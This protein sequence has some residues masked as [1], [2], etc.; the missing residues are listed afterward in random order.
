[1]FFY[2]IYKEKGRDYLVFSDGNSNFKMLITNRN[3]VERLL[4]L[5]IILNIKKSPDLSSKMLDKIKK[6]IE[7]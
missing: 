6:E 7:K 3:L 1:M 5:L 4:K 2:R